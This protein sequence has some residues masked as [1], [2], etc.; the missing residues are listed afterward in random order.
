MG[1]PVLGL[2]LAYKHKFFCGSW[3]WFSMA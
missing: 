3:Y 2:K 1:F